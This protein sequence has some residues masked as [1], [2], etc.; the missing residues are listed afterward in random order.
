MNNQQSLGGYKKASF[1]FYYMP[2]FYLSEYRDI[3][4]IIY[5]INNNCVYCI[6]NQL[7]IYSVISRSYIV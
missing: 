6:S 5:G 4:E 3:D 2:D 1:N 7:E